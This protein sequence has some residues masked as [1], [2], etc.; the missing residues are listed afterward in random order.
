[1]LNFQA[2]G[3][4]NNDEMFFKDVCYIMKQVHGCLD[5]YHVNAITREKMIS[6]KMGN[7]YQQFENALSINISYFKI[8]FLAF[9]LYY[10]Q[11]E[12]DRKWGK[13]WG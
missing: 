2:Q 9:C 13:E 10:S 11:S 4:V 8:I 7:V 3:E 6:R 12:I 1:M 5:A